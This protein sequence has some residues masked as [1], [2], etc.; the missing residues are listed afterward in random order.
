PETS[1]VF[2]SEV[3]MALEYLK[4]N[5]TVAEALRDATEMAFEALRGRRLGS[6]PKD[7]QRTLVTLYVQKR[8]Q[9]HGHRFF[10]AGAFC[11]SCEYCRLD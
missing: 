4:A 7:A 8:A 9:D 5:G 2:K 11:L 1:H 10:P 6:C 3:K